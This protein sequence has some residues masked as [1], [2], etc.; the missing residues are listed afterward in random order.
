ME[1]LQSK[2]IRQRI[3]KTPKTRRTPLHQKFQLL[4]MKTMNLKKRRLT[5]QTLTL[6]TPLKSSKNSTSDVKRD[7]ITRNLVATQ[8]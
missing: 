1:V 4:R 6:M 8:L 7:L 2:K 5:T 3:R